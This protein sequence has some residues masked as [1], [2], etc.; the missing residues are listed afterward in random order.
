VIGPIAGNIAREKASLAPVN[1]IVNEQRMISTAQNATP[2]SGSEKNGPFEPTQCHSLQK[3]SQYT[4]LH[5]KNH[6]MAL[7]RFR[8]GESCLRSSVEIYSRPTAAAPGDCGIKT[9]SSN[10]VGGATLLKGACQRLFS[11]Q[12]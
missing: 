11:Q 2:M 10:T 6:D 1:P 9:E 4:S 5:I 12:E 3:P 8:G 7:D